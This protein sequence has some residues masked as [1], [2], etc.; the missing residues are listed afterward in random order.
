VIG[1]AALSE[2]AGGTSYQTATGRPCPD[3]SVTPDCIPLSR[4]DGTLQRPGDVGWGAQS[5]ISHT[6]VHWDLSVDF[7]ARSPRLDLNDL[8]FLSEFN[9]YGGD[10]SLTYQQREP[11]GSV[12]NYN[13][14][15]A[16]AEQLTFDN[17]PTAQNGGLF[18]GL[19][20]TN[21]WSL[22]ATTV[23][24]LPGRWDIFETGDGARLQRPPAVTSSISLQS[25]P[26]RKAMFFGAASVNRLL[27]RDGW[28]VTGSSQLTFS[29]IPTLQLDLS[30]QMS[31]NYQ[32][33]R[34]WFPDGCYDDNGASCT[35]LSITRH[36]IFSDLDSGSLSF[37]SHAAYTFSP[38][39]S[40]Q[41][42]AQLFMARG[43]FTDF[44]SLTTM[45]VHPRLY[46]SDL[47]P[48]RHLSDLAP[49]Q[50]P[51]S[52]LDPVARGDSDTAGNFQRVA[53]NLNL[54]L[55]WEFFPG[56]AL[57]FVYSRAQSGSP[58][59]DGRS[60]RFTPGGLSVGPTEDVFLVKVSYFIR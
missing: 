35:P 33:T 49:Q 25:D 39:L 55:R 23:I 1:D 15:V 56:S 27:G 13:V 30:S 20:F 29:V 58:D 45:G 5:S 60:P 2:R 36:Y 53:L 46:L 9:A 28:G 17:L 21:F 57:L 47:H 37:T 18:G 40:L 52:P 59:L 19:R 44:A 32:A 50:D 54:V 51:P 24:G 31:L 16:Y 7:R 6:G 4:P 26:R 41:G 42:Y 8:G 43:K 11:H 22:N 14:G 34:L 48:Q 3:P 12:Q 38:R 10:V